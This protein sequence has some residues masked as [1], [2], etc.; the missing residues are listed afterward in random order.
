MSQR[1]A[2]RASAE[3]M[4]IVR[5]VTEPGS[6]SNFQNEFET[7]VNQ[8]MGYSGNAD[9]QALI[10]PPTATSPGYAEESVLMR[11]LQVP[12]RSPYV[13]SGF[14][15]PQILTRAGVTQQS[16]TTFT[17][18]VKHHAQLSAHQWITTI[19]W[20]LGALGL[21]G[22]M[23]GIFG[24]IPSAVVGHKL[25]KKQEN[26]NLTIAAE[27]GALIQCVQHWNEVYF[28]PRRLLI[29]VDLP[30]QTEDMATM[31][32]STSEDFQNRLSGHVSPSLP[33][34][35]D[36]SFSSKYSDEQVKEG[37][38]RMKAARRGRIVII[39]LDAPRSGSTSPPDQ[40]KSANPWRRQSPPSGAEKAE[41]SNTMGGTRE[42]DDGDVSMFA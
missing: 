7:K 1:Y 14:K 36:Y 26:H 16:W 3:P 35:E 6:G 2:Q 27:S 13:T 25:R 10:V 31:D 9:T 17:D 4:R 20:S 30:G 19:G 37:R 8:E 40:E 42:T 39:P 15:Y 29:R 34:T 18:E 41:H 28:K 21:G 5:E 22:M 12:A 24:F 11:G 33:L 23:V 32:V 38:T